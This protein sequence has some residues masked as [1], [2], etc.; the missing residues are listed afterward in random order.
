MFRQLEKHKK[1]EVI[2]QEVSRQI[3]FLLSRGPPRIARTT[4]AALLAQKTNAL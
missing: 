1:D 3:L 4:P 2:R